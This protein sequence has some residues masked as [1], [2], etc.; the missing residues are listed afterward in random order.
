[1]RCRHNGGFATLK[2]V[3]EFDNGRS[4]KP[5]CPQEGLSETE[6]LARR[7]R[8]RPELPIDVNGDETSRPGLSD[9]EFR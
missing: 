7:C 3:V 2:R 4:A 8:P 6:A 5:N 1:M 9:Q